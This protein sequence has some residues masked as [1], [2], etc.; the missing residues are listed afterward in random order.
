M[1]YGKKKSTFF[2]VGQTPPITARYRL[3]TTRCLCVAKVQHRQSSIVKL[4]CLVRYKK[5]PH[6]R[7]FHS[8]EALALKTPNPRKHPTQLTHPKRN[9]RNYCCLEPRAAHRP[10]AKLESEE[11][12]LST[13]PCEPIR[14]KAY[15][16]SCESERA[17]SKT[18]GNIQDRGQAMVGLSSTSTEAAME[19]TGQ[20][21]NLVKPQKKTAL[22]LSPGNEVTFV[23]R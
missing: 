11:E 18:G 2:A 21:L 13:S 8:S 9:R 3:K 16:H 6:L 4:E 14:I 1:K 19:G 17:H 7:C 22:Q 23:A 5:L 20:P 10:C 15:S 12:P